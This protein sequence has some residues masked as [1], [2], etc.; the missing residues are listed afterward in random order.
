MWHYKWIIFLIFQLTYLNEINFPFSSKPQEKQARRT[1]KKI[2]Q[3][4]ICYRIFC[5]RLS[6]GYLFIRYI[7]CLS[8]RSSRRRA[9]HSLHFSSSQQYYEIYWAKREGLAQNQ[10]TS[11]SRVGANL[12]LPNPSSAPSPLQYIGFEISIM[13]W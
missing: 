13:T 12:D 6:L 5:L 8:S 4:N 2:W 11:R 7:S 1:L 9:L 10:W 3:N